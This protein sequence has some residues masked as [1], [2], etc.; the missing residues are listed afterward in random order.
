MPP[1]RGFKPNFDGTVHLVR[2]GR[3]LCGVVTCEMSPKHRWGALVGQDVHEASCKDCLT[4]KQNR[5]LRARG[6]KVPKR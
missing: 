6:L 4:Q 2:G 5:D 1:P 3:T